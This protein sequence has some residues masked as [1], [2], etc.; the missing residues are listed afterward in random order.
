MLGWSVNAAAATV[1]ISAGGGA[2]AKAEGV[3]FSCIATIVPALLATLLDS[4]SPCAASSL[5]ETYCR[6]QS[7]I[8][9]A[10]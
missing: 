10:H 2:D 1:L 7:G 4:T 9:C 8:A 6:L 3:Q 5:F